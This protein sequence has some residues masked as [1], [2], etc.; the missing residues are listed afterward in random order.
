MRLVSENYAFDVPYEQIIL[1][2][3]GGYIYFTSKENQI[4]TETVLAGYSTAEKAIKVMKMV[5]EADG[6]GETVFIFPKDE[7]VY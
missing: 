6:K 5:L 1:K 3:I 4:G 7:D 2:R